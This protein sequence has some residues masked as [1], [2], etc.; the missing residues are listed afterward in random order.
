MPENVVTAAAQMRTATAQA[1]R[2]GIATPLPFNAVIA[3]LTPAPFVFVDTPTPQN[4]ATAQAWAA[5]ATAVAAT[6]GTFTPLPP[7]AVRA[8]RTPVPTPL[9]LV[10]Y[11][12]RLPP[13]HTTDTHA[14][15]PVR[16]AA[17]AGGQDPVCQ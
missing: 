13:V 6:T 4:A 7:N 10:L 12:D 17:R 3:T 5:Y 14:D 9:P 2:A 8:T 11:L 16:R 15:R 1:G